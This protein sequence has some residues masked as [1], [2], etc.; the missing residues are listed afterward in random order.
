VG[1]AGIVCP[2]EYWAGTGGAGARWNGLKG[3]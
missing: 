3:F 1:C 2:I